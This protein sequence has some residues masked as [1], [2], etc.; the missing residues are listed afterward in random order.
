MEQKEI[1]LLIISASITFFVL[2]VSL[3]ALFIL[4]QRRRDIYQ[5]EIN[6]VR[7]EMVEQTLK[8]ISW[9]IH[10]NIGQILSTMNLYGYKIHSEVPEKFQPPVEE[11]QELI[12][13]A[14]SEVRGLSK[15]LNTDYIKNVGLIKSVEL[16][17]DRFKRLSFM[18][19][20]FE[21]MGQPFTIPNDSEV[22]LLRIL[23]EF[24][25]NTMKYAQAKKID[26][27]FIFEEKKLEVYVKDDGIGFDGSNIQG[28]GLLNM[29]NRARLI[30]A[31]LKLESELGKG[32]NLEIIYKRKVT[33]NDE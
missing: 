14:I 10:D 16:E 28:T 22:F 1:Y 7:V 6:K 11:L 26:V 29:K 12:Q 4:M 25:S 3:A 5:K 20:E 33:E 15:S 17:L 2:S 23:Q 19:T 27:K 30:G 24:F 18:E 8:N 21:V 31:F 32:T 9:E 13:T